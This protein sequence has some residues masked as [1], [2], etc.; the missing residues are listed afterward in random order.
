MGEARSQ[1]DLEARRR[2]VTTYERNLV[3][4]AGAGT[5]KTSLLVERILNQVV[6]QRLPLRQLAAITFTEKAA[7][8]MRERFEAGLVRLAALAQA[9]SAGVLDPSQEADRAFAYLSERLDRQRIEKEARRALA[10]LPRATIS[11]IH[12]FCAR[13]LR[14]HPV[15]SGVDPSFT[16]DAGLTL[17]GLLTELWQEFLEGTHGPEGLQ[18]AEWSSLLQALDLRELESLAFQL[19]DF[20]VPVLPGESARPD[21]VAVLAP[22]VRALREQIEALLEPAA[23]P[24]RGPESYLHTVRSLLEELPAGGLARFR[25]ALASASFLSSRG[26]RGLLDGAP[27]GA[28]AKPEATACAKDARAL[29]EAMLSIDEELVARAIQLVTPFVERARG[30]ARRRGILSFDALLC[31]TRDLLAHHPSVRGKLG[32]QYRLLLVDEFQDTDPLQYEIVF[33]LAEAPTTAPSDD[34]FRTRLEPGKLFI[35]GDPKQSI[36]HFR[37]ADISAYHQAVAHVQACGGQRLALTTSWRARPEL[38]EPL[39]PLFESLLQPRTEL[40][41]EVEPDFE[42]MQSGRDAANDGPR[43]ELWTVGPAQQPRPAEPARRAEGEVIADWIAREHEAGRLP[44]ADVAILFRA[45]SQVHLYTQPLREWGIPF[46]LESRHSP[47]EHSEGLE[48]QALLRA[49]ANPNDAPALLGVLRSALGATPDGELLRFARSLDGPW[50]YLAVDPD[51]QLFPNVARGYALLRDWHERSLSQPPGELLL[52]LLDESP[53]LTLHA[54]AADGLQRVTVLRALVDRLV[55]VARLDP[56]HSLSTLLPWLQ[57]QDV[58]PPAAL[59]ED[60]VRIFS[61]HGA[62]GLEFPTVILPDLGRNPG[63]EDAR[64]APRI[65]VAWLPIVR[66]LAVSTDAGCSASW[67]HHT[68]EEKRHAQAEH[69]RL[70]Y[71]ACTRARERLILVHAPRQN[72]SR[73]AWVRFLSSWGYPESGL[74]SDGALE[75]SPALLHRVAEPQS[76]ERIPELSD[77]A[78]DWA[79]AVRRTQA[80]SEQAARQAA[81]LFQRPSGLREQEEAAGEM[82]ET[83]ETPA[84]RSTDRARLLGLAVHEALERWDFKSRDALT[85]RLDSAL[86][87]A[88][89]DSAVELE[90]LRREAMEII[91]G[92]LESELP[93]YLSS[94][95]VLG[96]ELPILFRDAQGRAWNGTLDLLYREPDGRLVVADYKTDRDPSPEARQRYREQLEAYARGI[97]LAFPEAPPPAQELLYVRTGERVRIA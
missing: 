91:Q 71:V 20:S 40:E 87:R 58:L 2:A 15:E 89:R 13:A 54:A 31:L 12:A 8:E 10:E 76:A 82:L 16:V 5:G 83:E 29:L 90:A 38:L 34:P 22:R 62:K 41:R 42:R 3:I 51:P 74:G 56:G 39:N 28:K 23:V 95:E 35:V 7:L 61:V 97:A 11:T 26:R 49:I 4:V 86:I 21:P 68:W 70:F 73:Q 85:A 80:V 32:G 45:L 43:V 48:L 33:F 24:D 25:E 59:G 50:R 6:E 9:S 19:A 37:R 27:P 44:Y 14:A 47:L 77:P 93:A 1:S 63:G 72:R 67:L 52:R 96:R 64:G 18:Q 84:L 53:F 66:A 65:R 36:Y 57:S 55:D 78:E 60:K 69:K 17:A 81:P 88:A 46:S 92:L 94:L 75:L 79:Q 30:E